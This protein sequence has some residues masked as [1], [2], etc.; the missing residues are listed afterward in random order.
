MAQRIEDRL[1]RFATQLD[2]A[3]GDNLVS[4][5][6]YGSA[7]QG[8]HDPKRSDLNVLVILRDGSPAALRP[9]AGAVAAWAKAGEPPPLIYAEREW[10]FSTDVFPI[11]IE[12]MRA[13]YRLLRGSDPF[14]GISTTA[15]DQRHE[16]EREVRGKLLQLR[17]EYAAAAS[18][19]RALGALLAH[20]APTFFVLFRALLRLAR[21]DPPR[22]PAPLVRDTAALVGFDP[23]AFDWVLATLAQRKAGRLEPYDPRGAAYLAAIEQVAEHVDSMSG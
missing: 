13:A 16:L 23:G 22:Q 2:E 8:G 7:A 21:R 17:A 15:A 14:E 19:G 3:L 1:E 11:E 20:A 18:D 9:I 6:L 5:V 4:L 10:R 12:D